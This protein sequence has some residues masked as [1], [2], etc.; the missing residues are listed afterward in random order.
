MNSGEDLLRRIRENS[1][2]IHAGNIPTPIPLPDV[3]RPKILDA[4]LGE[5]SAASG[6]L[7]LPVAVITA[8]FGLTTW[9]LTRK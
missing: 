9:E 6:V 5:L 3:A 2:V 8:I 7:F 4:V 1:E